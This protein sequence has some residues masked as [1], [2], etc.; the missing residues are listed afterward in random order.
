[1]FD[2]YYVTVT[3]ELYNGTASISFTKVTSIHYQIIS[4]K[5]TT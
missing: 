5:D 4:K 2:E 3:S 1:M